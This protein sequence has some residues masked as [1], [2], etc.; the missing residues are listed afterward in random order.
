MTKIQEKYALNAENIDKA[1]EKFFAVCQELKMDRKESIKQRFAFENALMTWLS[2]FDEEHEFELI[3]YSKLLTPHVALRCVD[4]QSVNPLLAEGD[5][6][7]NSILNILANAPE[8]YYNGGINTVIFK[9]KKPSMHPMLQLGLI[10]LLSVLIGVLGKAILPENVVSGMLTYFIDPIY[11]KFLGVLGCIAGP[12]I[13][14]SVAW[15]IYGIGDVATFNKIG[16]SLMGFLVFCAMVA[17]FLATAFFPMFGLNLSNGGTDVSQIL[18]IFQV[19]LDMIP[20]NIVEPF[21]L[22]NTIQIIVL[23]VVT[24]IALLYL[25][26]RSES[27]ARGINQLNNIINFTL[28]A[29]G[30]LVPGFVALT[31][32]NIIWSGKISVGLKMWKLALIELV[33]FIIICAAFLLI[34]ASRIK[35]KP[36]I[37]FKKILSP[38]LLAFST[39][40]S[41]SAFGDLVNT[42]KDKLGINKS[43]VEFGV[44]L[45][46]VTQKTIVS[47][48]YALVALYVAGQEGISISFGWLVL[49]ALVSAV[50]AIATPPIPGGTSIAYTMLFTQLGLP[51]ENIGVI[52][53]LDMIMDFAI[54]GA[55][56]FCSPLALLNVANKYGLVNK[57]VLNSK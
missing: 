49:A 42:C 23:A 35:T 30:T 46:I 41:S 8:Y 10:I 36:N 37:I 32:V 26:K 22:G 16:K 15:G 56:V 13:F 29:I 24:G 50:T 12:L 57:E 55:N 11:S 40:S 31:M 20:T 14:L 47:I 4:G 28:S 6:Y 7:S 38:T 3:V 9:L 51:T 1:S 18:S 27:I 54:T 2:S 43:L 52:L 33:S 48:S 19:F 21:A 45:C 25:G 5:L 39:A 17:S 44:P 34:T 53:A